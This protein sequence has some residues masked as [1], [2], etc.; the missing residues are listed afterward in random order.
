[1]SIDVDRPQTAPE[2]QRPNKKPTRFVAPQITLIGGSSSSSNLNK[3]G[4]RQHREII[5]KGYF[6]NLKPS[7]MGN[8]RTV[9][10][11][12]DPGRTGFVMMDDFLFRLDKAKSVD[13]F[14]KTAHNFLMHSVS[15]ERR[16]GFKSFRDIVAL[17]LPTASPARVD[18]TI[19]AGEQWI[20]QR[21]ERRASRRLST[22]RLSNA[23]RLQS[24]A[25]KAALTSAFFLGKDN[26]D[27]DE[28]VVR[29][30]ISLSS[31]QELKYMFASL[32]EHGHGHVDLR[33]LERYFGTQD[34]VRS[35]FHRVTTNVLDFNGFLKLMLPHGFQPCQY[36]DPEKVPTATS[37]QIYR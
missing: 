23:E 10:D 4:G 13:Q 27:S 29:A 11:R 8:L 16:E 19:Q 15:K 12:V 31:L 34:D 9:F 35:L 14:L 24:V 25:F 18:A 28:D 22:G 26:D 21:V 1:M 32:D 5:H 37:D 7:E 17:L 6:E 20:A 2:G 30:D 3:S 33:D 36:P